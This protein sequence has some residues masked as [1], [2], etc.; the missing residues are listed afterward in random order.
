M[1][2]GDNI[3]YKCINRLGIDPDNGWNRTPW[4]HD[5]HTNTHNKKLYP[6]EYMH[7]ILHSLQRSSPGSLVHLSTHLD[8]LSESPLER[9]HRRSINQSLGNSVEDMYVRMQRAIKQPSIVTHF[10]AEGI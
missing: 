9:A 4:M 6:V 2:R 7:R 10:P 5:L 3:R 1:N 8:Q